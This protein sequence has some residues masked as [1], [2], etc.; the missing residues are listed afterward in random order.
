MNPNINRQYRRAAHY[1]ITHIRRQSFYALPSAQSD[2]L[3]SP[4]ISML[5]TFAAV[6]RA[7]ESNA[8]IAEAILAVGLPSFG[9]A[10]ED[11]RW[12][13]CARPSDLDKARSTIRQMYRDWAFEGLPERQAAFVPIM[14][15]LE[16]HFSDLA[17]SERH[18]CKVLVPGAG[19]GRLVFELCAAGWTVE[20]NEI[21]YHQLIASNYILNF[22]GGAG[23]HKLH[24]W[25]LNF[26]NHKSRAHQ[27]QAVR[28]PDVN[29][30]EYL[31]EAS[32]RLA[33]EVHYSDRM[34]MTAGDFC[35]LYRQLE[36]RERFNAV[37]TC[38]FIDTA[39]NVIN[40]IE[41]VRFCL[42]TGGIWINLGPLLWHFESGPTPAEIEKQSGRT[43]KGPRKDGNVDIDAGIGEPGSFELCN[44]EVLALLEHYGF[45]V[46]EH[47]DAPPTGYIQDSASMLQNVYHPTFWIARKR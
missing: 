46:I 34:T 47:R 24:P 44:D 37:T 33:S 12:E 14:S 17:P 4:P 30:V 5:K 3:S 15:A 25:A 20:G 2:V 40:Y 18:Q 43:K 29:P 39:P 38:F 13:N 9:I 27:L 26:S 11:H 21:S 23:A 6:D 42:A 8:E 22:V 41:T 32:T 10:A 35:V 1:N 36:H 31:E 28:I 7:V 16:K 45:D 19:L